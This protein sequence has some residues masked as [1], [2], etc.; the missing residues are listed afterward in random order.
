[1][2]FI[3]FIALVVSQLIMAR[4][5]SL[6]RAELDA[7]RQAYQQVID[8][9]VQPPGGIPAQRWNPGGEIPI[10][11]LK[12]MAK[13][14]EATPADHLEKW[15][16]ELARIAD[17]EFATELERQGCRTDF[18]NRMGMAYDGLKWDAATSNS[19][20]ERA[21]TMPT[22][23]VQLWIE[24]LEK[25][26][27]KEVAYPHIVPLALVPVGALH[28]NDQFSRQRSQKYLARLRQLTSRDVTL[29][30]EKV[31]EFG[32]TDIDAAVNV[33]LSDAYFVDEN[34]QRDE[35]IDRLR[36]SK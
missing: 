20:L 29:W 8:S 12:L 10:D 30:R 1:M 9:K 27:E 15:M 25:V 26:L 31:D 21:R 16:L 32:G 17:Q 14:L 7:V 11:A 2:L 22:D 18:A 4:Q 28:P 3:V 13:R 24:S 35:F 23:E 34:F 5:L 19:L 36:P 33:I 6:T